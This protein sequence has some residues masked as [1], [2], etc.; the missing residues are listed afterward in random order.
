MLGVRQLRYRHTQQSGRTLGRLWQTT[1]FASLVDPP[2]DQS[3][4]ARLV[5][6]AEAAAVVSVEELVSGG[7]KGC[8]AYLKEVDVVAEVRVAVEHCVATV[9]CTAARLVAAE[10]VGEAV[11]ELLGTFGQVHKVATAGGHLHLQRVAEELVEA[12]KTLN[13][14]RVSAVYEVDG[15]ASMLT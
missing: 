14:W 13:H 9:D 8:G 6:R 2:G 11:L 7:L 5:R 3:S 1:V 4:P 15:V 10:D 12:L